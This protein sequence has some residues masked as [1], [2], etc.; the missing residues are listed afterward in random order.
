MEEPKNVKF[1]IFTTRLGYYTNDDE[2]LHKR[3]LEETLSYQ[4]KEGRVI[5]NIGGFQS[6]MTAHR[7]RVQ[8]L[9]RH[10]SV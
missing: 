1:D 6:Q 9:C 8:R 10:R 3:M 7:G 4:N 2:V 5:S